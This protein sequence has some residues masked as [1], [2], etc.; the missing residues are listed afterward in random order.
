M[1]TY[2]TQNHEQ[3]RPRYLVYTFH[4]ICWPVLCLNA[5]FYQWSLQQHPIV[6]RFTGSHFALSVIVIDVQLSLRVDRVRDW[7]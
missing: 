6:S 7:V 3:L 1:D 5:A 2:T 4:Y